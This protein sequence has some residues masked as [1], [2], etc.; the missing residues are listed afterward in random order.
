MRLQ[1]RNVVTVSQIDGASVVVLSMGLIFIFGF[2]KFYFLKKVLRHFEN[3][4]KYFFG[5]EKIKIFGIFKNRRFSKIS[6]NRG[7]QKFQIFKIFG[8]SKI[9][10]F[11]DLKNMIWNFQNDVELLLANK[12]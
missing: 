4:G 6:K 7:F 5:S 11:S 10:K 12:I 1:N 9:F 3:S 8:F 2:A